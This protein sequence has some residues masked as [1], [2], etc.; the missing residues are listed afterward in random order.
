MSMKSMIGVAVALTAALA[1]PALAR[2]T[3]HHATARQVTRYQQTVTI[4][5][6]HPA[7]DVYNIRG[8][9]VGTDP[10]P[11]IRDQLARCRY[12]NC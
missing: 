11:F 10:D 1:S 2:P 3:A 9:Y 8:H 7:W 4:H 5:S 12:G 6:T